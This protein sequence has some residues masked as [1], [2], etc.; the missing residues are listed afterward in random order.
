MQPSVDDSSTLHGRLTGPQSAAERQRVL[1]R[2]Q[3]I[4]L[5]LRALALRGDSPANFAQLT[6]ARTAVACALDAMRRIPVVQQAK[7]P[8]RPLKEAKGRPKFP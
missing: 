8:P 2:L 4:E 7:T 6:A 3:A 5:R 1:D